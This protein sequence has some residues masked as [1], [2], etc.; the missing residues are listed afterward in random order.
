MYA[1]VCIKYS[2][3]RHIEDLGAW[4]NLKQLQDAIQSS[5]FLGI[6]KLGTKYYVNSSKEF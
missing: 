4:Q 6:L 3:E 5:P 1:S 2:D